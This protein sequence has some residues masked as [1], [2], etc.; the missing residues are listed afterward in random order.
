M[1]ETGEHVA[2]KQKY[3]FVAMSVLYFVY[4]L[5]FCIH[6]IR[7]WHSM[8]HSLHL[9]TL[10]LAIFSLGLWVLLRG[11]KASGFAMTMACFIFIAAS[12]L[13]FHLF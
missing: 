6:L 11:E 2:W 13:A 12:R 4:W 7:R 3:M 9:D 8:D 1:S 10:G 5:W